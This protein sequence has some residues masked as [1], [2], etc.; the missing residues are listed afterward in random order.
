MAIKNKYAIE[1]NYIDN[2]YARSKEPIKKV[3][4]LV[5][6]ETAN[7]SADAD[8]HQRYFDGIDYYASA[9]T[10]IDDGKI[11]EIIPLDEKAWHVN[12]GKPMDNQL[13]GDDA[14]DAAIGVE[15]CRTGDFKKAYDK[16]VWYFAYLCHKFGLNPQTDI[17]AHSKLD[18]ERRSDPQSWLEPNGISWSHFIRDVQYYFDNWS[19]K[20]VDRDEQVKSVQIEKLEVDGYWGAKT[21]T[22]LQQYLDTP[23]DGIIS[24]QIKTDITKQI[25]NVDYGTG[26]SLV[27]KAL[28]R[29]IGAE[30]D[31]YFGPKS[32]R[33]LQAYLGTPADGVIS[34]PSLMVKELQRRLN[35]GKL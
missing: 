16:Y 17:V 27:V 4:F 21:T 24:G 1:Q 34:R 3:L 12:Y 18:P 11:L 25:G 5:G 35:K 29:L 2:H 30:Q 9:H 26:G 10:F 19:L 32:L 28:Q 13:Y 20:T 23:V 14:N 15:L 33:K 8:D 7:N 31:G 6:H 22:A